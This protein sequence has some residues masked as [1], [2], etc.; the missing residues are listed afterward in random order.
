MPGPHG[1]EHT[2]STQG[3]ALRSD[4]KATWRLSGYRR[5][6][7]GPA[8]PLPVTVCLS[9]GFGSSRLPPVGPP[10]DPAFLAALVGGVKLF[11]ILRADEG[12]TPGGPGAVDPPASHSCHAC[13]IYLCTCPV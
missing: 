11:F 5:V 1:G 7:V 9:D 3:R 4:F 6:L 12:G 10:G 8:S 13:L 2:S